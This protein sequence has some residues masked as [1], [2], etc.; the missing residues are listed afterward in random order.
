MPNGKV[1]IRKYLVENG[2][3]E[4]ELQ[5]KKV[6]ELRQIMDAFMKSK[7]ASET[8]LDGVEEQ[9]EEVVSKV[10]SMDIPEEQKAPPKPCDPEWTQ[11]VLGHF[12]DDEVDGDN[13]RVEGLRRVAELLI[14]PIISEDC[15]LVQAANH[16]NQMT[17]CVKATVTFYS[18]E[19]QR[20]I[21]Y[22]A[23]ADANDGN[24]FVR[25]DTDFTV[26]LTAMADT[27]AKG[28]VFRNALKLRRVVA[29]EEIGHGIGLITQDSDSISSDAQIAAATMFA[30]RVN[31][32]L[33]ELVDAM[34]FAHE[35]KSGKVKLSTLTH[36][37]MIGL[38]KKLNELNAERLKD[39]NKTEELLPV[40]GE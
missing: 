15:D 5:G 20:E 18:N 13:P 9:N 8:F 23:L 11:F 31:V 17:A 4:E 29:A 6:E 37:D 19:F 16:D 30:G 12:Q 22:S 26:Y 35:K 14:G 3:S 32:D 40:Q 38:L 34:G 21:S 28:R 2:Y 1:E 36:S 25:G 7:V 39:G 27:R 24:I 10:E 33:T